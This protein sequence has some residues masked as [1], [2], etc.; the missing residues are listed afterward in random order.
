M[1][2]FFP[3]LMMNA[4]DRE[5]PPPPP[6]VRNEEE[7]VCRPDETERKFHSHLRDAEKELL[8]ANAPSSDS[9]EEK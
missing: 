7:P 9:F 5:P 2:W 6:V 3:L 8:K 4:A 1:F